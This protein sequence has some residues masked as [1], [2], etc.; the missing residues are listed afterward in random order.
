[1]KIHVTVDDI[2][3]AGKGLLNSPL[4]RAVQRIL[5]KSWVVFMCTRA[6]EMAPPY[7][8]VSLPAKATQRCQEH[9]R[10]GEIQPF[11]FDMDYEPHA[12]EGKA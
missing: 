12:G 8:F 7:R 5:G 6:M 1:M 2:R 11:D 9:Q 4:T 10:T 3:G